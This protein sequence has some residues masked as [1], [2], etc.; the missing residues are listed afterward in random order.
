MSR[1]PAAPK[2]A[3]VPWTPP[4]PTRPGRDGAP[5][6][7]S[8]SRLLAAERELQT[9]K[10]M[11][12]QLEINRSLMTSTPF[13]GDFWPQ[14]LG[15]LPLDPPPPPT[16]PQ[17][18]PSRTLL[19]EHTGETTDE[20]ERD[21][22]GL[23][24]DSPANPRGGAYNHAQSVPSPPKGGTSSGEGNTAED[25][26]Q[27]NQWEGGEAELL[28]R[29]KRKQAEIPARGEGDTKGE[30][31]YEDVDGDLEKDVDGD[32]DEDVDGGLEGMGG[33]AAIRYILQC[34]QRGVEPHPG[35][36]ADA[37]RGYSNG[38]R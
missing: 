36:L 29:K 22:G 13:A 17:T 31:E 15:W 14:E 1:R 20:D 12:E 24:S 4:G 23:G 2:N 21:G 26:K 25:L 10:C 28:Q 16:P 11:L 3:P 35:I 9:L 38:E 6:V 27:K 8:G 30:T 7:Y 19:D 18:P 5:A 33:D 32:L 37:S 34:A